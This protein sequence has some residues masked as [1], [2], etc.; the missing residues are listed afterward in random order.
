MR[1]DLLRGSI[2]AFIGSIIIFFFILKIYEQD[3]G[4]HVPIF[5]IS[6][7]FGILFVLYKPGRPVQVNRKT[8]G[9][10]KEYTEYEKH[11]EL[12]MMHFRQRS[13][14]VLS[15]L[16]YFIWLLYIMLNQEQSAKNDFDTLFGSAFLSFLMT[17]LLAGSVQWFQI[18]W[19]IGTNRI[20]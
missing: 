17:L 7:L 15:I 20:K 11:L 4:L 10:P 12:V 14:V 19:A 8:F 2:V 18:W 3:N 16:P 13:I 9:L 5:L 1:I 6:G